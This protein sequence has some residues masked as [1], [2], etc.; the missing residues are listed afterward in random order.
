MLL[1]LPAQWKGGA[2][3]YLAI[4]PS[5]QQAFYSIVVNVQAPG[6]WFA[7][8]RHNYDEVGSISFNSGR[9]FSFGKK[10]L[11]EL[12][13]MVGFVT[14]SVTG[15]NFNFDQEFEWKSFYYSS[16]IQY[17][18][19][20]KSS[21]LDFFYTWQEAGYSLSKNFFSGVSFQAVLPHQGK[22]EYS[23]GI[24]IG[25]SA[26][27]WSFPLYVFDPF[28]SSRHILAGICFNGKFNNPIP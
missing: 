17:M 21:G 25:F 16:K 28:R 3:Q 13:P 23:K 24:V 1:R 20:L 11:I 18:H 27:N 14:G 2:E 9:S 5:A 6:G 7:E 12:K 10:L 19:S 26:G 22:I 4:T 8:I 15:L